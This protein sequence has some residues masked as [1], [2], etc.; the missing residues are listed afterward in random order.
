M[1]IQK[2]NQ[3]TAS[4]PAS[5][6]QQIERA[7]AILKQSEVAESNGD[8]S[9]AV[10]KAR[11]SLRVLASIGMTSPDHATLI[12]AA[13]MGYRGYEIETLV[14]HDEQVVMPRT[15]LGIN[16]GYDIVN[17]KRAT[18]TVVRGKIL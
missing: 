4:L 11:E 12:M 15:F 17:L 9:L 6:Q 14:R 18:H 1:S 7:E 10:V 16:V 2:N 8:H 3:A 5:V 13:E